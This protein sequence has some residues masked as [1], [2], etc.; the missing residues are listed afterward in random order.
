MSSYSPLY[1]LSIRHGY[2]DDGLCRAFSCTPAPSGQEIMRRRG[3]LFRQTDAPVDSSVL[4]AWADSLALKAG[5]ARYRGKVSFYGAA[6]VVPGCVIELKGLGK[7]FNG[8]AFI[9]SVT[10]II[11]KNEW[12][13]EAGIG[14][15]PAGI[16]GEPGVV[17]HAAAGLF[18]RP[19][20]S[21]YGGG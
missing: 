19:G 3:L 8:N 21:T 1:T 20:G 7:R 4:K 16:T 6:E 15:A 12:I 10:H 5:L 13:T 17:G 9:G 14:I 11:E 18:P 2:F